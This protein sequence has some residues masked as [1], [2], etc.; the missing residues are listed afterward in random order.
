VKISINISK[1]IKKL[2]KELKK[3]KKILDDDYLPKAR[4]YEEYIYN[5]GKRN[6]FS[7]ADH[8]ATI[9]SMK[10]D[11]MKNGHLKPGYN[12]QMGTENQF[13]LGYTIHQKPS[14]S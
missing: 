4:K 2:D 14:D 10:E 6:S 5:A 8:D 11:Y 3:K 7:K 9:M 1:R 13:I 12:I